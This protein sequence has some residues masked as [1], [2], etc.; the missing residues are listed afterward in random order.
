MTLLS[1]P[2][3]DHGILA[4]EAEAIGHCAADTGAARRGLRFGDV[5][6]VA[7]DAAAHHLGEDAG[8]PSPGVFLRLH[9]DSAGALAEDEAVAVAIEGARGPRR[10]V[11]A[12]GECAHVGQT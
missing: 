10:L 4:A 12:R 7:G 3:D 8:A 9:H 2:E 11:V 6:G 1:V 5:P